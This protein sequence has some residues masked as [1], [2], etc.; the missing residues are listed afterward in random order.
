MNMLKRMLM[1]VAMAC[2]VS[3]GAF[4]QKRDEDKR[5]PKPDNTK[6]VVQPKQEKPPQNSNQG[7]KRGGDKKGKP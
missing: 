6:V 1:A 5:P 3:A 2:L 4:A 7:D